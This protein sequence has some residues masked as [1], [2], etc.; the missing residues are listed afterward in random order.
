L[1]GGTGVAA[2]GGLEP[3][4][5]GCDREVVGRYLSL[6]EP[7][8]SVVT[9]GRRDGTLT[10][11]P[12]FWA[13]ARIL[14]PAGV[15][16]FQMEE[17]A[18]RR[19]VFH[20]SAA[21][22]VRSL[23]IAGMSYRAPLRRLGSNE[24]A[25]V[26]RLH[27]GEVAPAARAFLAVGGGDAP[28]A[29]LVARRMMFLPSRAAIIHRFLEE[30]ARRRPGV[31]AVWSAL[32][33]AR[34]Q[35][36]HGAGAAECYRRALSLDPRD[37]DALAAMLRLRLDAAPDSA[38]KL[39]FGDGDLFAPPR[40]EEIAAVRTDWSARN[41]APRNVQVMRGE[42]LSFAGMPMI[43]RLVAHSV[44]GS[45]HYGVVIVPAGA[46]A[47]SCPV[48]VEAHGVSWNFRPIPVPGGLTSPGMLA[49][50][51]GRVVYVVP[52]FRGESLVF[53]DETLTSDGD[54][55]DAWDGA[56]DDVL[57]MLNV[58]P[59]VAPEADTRRVVVFGRSRGGAVALLAGIRDRRFD[60]VVAWA[61]PSDW[62][63]GMGLLG[64]SRRELL[65][66]GLARRSEP[67]QTAGQFIQYF[68]QGALNGREDLSQV[69]HH[70]IASSARYFAESLPATE[71]HYGVDDA[72]VPERNGHL[73]L[74]RGRRASPPV[75]ARFHPDAGHDQDLFDAPRQSRHFLL[76]A[77]FGAGGGHGN[78]AKP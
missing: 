45:R 67:N 40:A 25:P 63:D 60:R 6:D 48:L 27:R 47:G 9:V 28:L 26:E 31:A 15:D 68:L 61:A 3:Q 20:R 22:C 49:E 30:I 12:M 75:V 59:A 19:F 36:G 78:T 71:V 4:S 1:A 57:A 72:I 2:P 69:R 58:V 65:R 53:G 39:P 50:D 32:G 42:T 18:E 7:V 10:V 17:R 23:E 52:S 16:S 34:L 73:L 29:V 70:L 56:T 44:H 77:L 64:W 5:N 46:E 76:S 14:V 74:Q 33:D 37:A 66:E 13:P 24:I 55:N 38:W 62:F 8:E 41:L 21:G 51:A 11:K 43:A 54:R 35:A